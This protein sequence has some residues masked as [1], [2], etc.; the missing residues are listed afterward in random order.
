MLN[1]GDAAWIGPVAYPCSVRS[2]NRGQCVLPMRRFRLGLKFR[3]DEARLS[4][5]WTMPGC[6]FKLGG[7]ARRRGVI[8]KVVVSAKRVKALPRRP[9]PCALRLGDGG[10]RGRID[11]CGRQ[12]LWLRRLCLARRGRV[13]KRRV[14]CGRKSLSLVDHALP[15][16]GG[17]P[18]PEE[19]RGFAVA[20]FR[21]LFVRCHGWLLGVMLRNVERQGSLVNKIGEMGKA[22]GA[23]AKKQRREAIFEPF[24]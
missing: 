22:C 4:L 5:R 3:S 13:V 7:F 14:G 6:G 24:I 23:S 18:F 20:I 17:G 10:L 8:V 2:F 19:G 1:K 16:C 15:N 11:S 21:I 9:K 12:I